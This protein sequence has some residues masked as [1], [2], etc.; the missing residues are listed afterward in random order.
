MYIT[1]DAYKIYVSYIIY[2]IY[3]RDIK[4]MY[5]DTYK[6]ICIMIH[7]EIYVLYDTYKNICIILHVIHMKICVFIL[8]RNM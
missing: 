8:C 4:Y 3:M 6:N 1:Y 5:Y 7:I 2:K